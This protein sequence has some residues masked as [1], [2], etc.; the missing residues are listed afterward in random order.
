MICVLG[1]TSRSEAEKGSSRRCVSGQILGDVYCILMYTLAIAYKH[2][3]KLTRTQVLSAF[4][5]ATPSPIPPFL[6]AAKPIRPSRTSCW[7]LLSSTVWSLAEGETPVCVS[8]CVSVCV[9][10]TCACYMC[11]CVCARVC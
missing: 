4:T 10:C 11:V 9:V 2:T 1:V 5:R 8:M 3:H 6:M 7:A